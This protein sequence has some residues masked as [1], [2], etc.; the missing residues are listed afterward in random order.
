MKLFL[1]N[2]DT[3]LFYR[4]ALAS[5][6]GPVVAVWGTEEA[7]VRGLPQDGECGNVFLHVLWMAFYFQKNWASFVLFCKLVPIVIEWFIIIMWPDSFLRGWSPIFVPL[8]KKLNSIWYPT[9]YTYK[10]TRTYCQVEEPSRPDDA[11][12]AIHVSK[13]GLEHLMERHRREHLHARAHT[14]AWF[15]S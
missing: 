12:Q 8:S 4:N 13:H 7:G 6:L 9:M 2:V 11:E 3:K 5:I 15:S 10:Y 1:I 14:K